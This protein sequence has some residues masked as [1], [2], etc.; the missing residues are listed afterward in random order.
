MT[1]KTHGRYD[2]SA[3]T[4]RKD[5]SWP[6]G[7]RLAVY[8]GLNIEHFAYGAGE[9]HLLTV[10]NPPP[11]PRT[12]AW[13]DYGNRVGAW[14]L[15]ELA[16]ALQLPMALLVNTELYDYCPEMVAAWSARG[17]EIVAHGRT[18][19]ERQAEFRRRHPGY[20]RRY[21]P[22][23][24]QIKAPG[25]FPIDPFFLLIAVTFPVVG[26]RPGGAVIVGLCAGLALDALSPASF[27][28][29]MG[30]ASLAGIGRA[31]GSS[32]ASMSLLMVIG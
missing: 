16:E 10:A 24:A 26:M 11:D 25:S 21:K 8:L 19:A 13:R 4:E 7:K 15:L 9:G 2:Y 5:Y 1:L 29:G 23:V 28:A 27:G 18:N 17:D 31:G 3:I 30:C 22:T 20:N 32:L 14:R 12:F 6:G